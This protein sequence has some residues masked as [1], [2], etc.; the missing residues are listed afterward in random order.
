MKKLLTIVCMVFV[1][2]A[3]AQSDS[4]ATD[5]LKLPQLIK[6]EDLRLSVYPNPAAGNT[7]LKMHLSRAQYLKIDITD[8]QGVTIRTVASQQFNTSDPS[9]Y[10]ETYGLTSVTYLLSVQNEAGILLATTFLKIIR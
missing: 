4:L 2:N 9:V 6:N 7:S 8:L 3:F 5:S 10:I 1:A